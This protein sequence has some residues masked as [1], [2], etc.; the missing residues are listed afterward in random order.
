[1][2]IGLVVLYSAQGFFQP[3]PTLPPNA[4]IIQIDENPWEIG[5]NFPVDCGIQGD[6]KS[7]LAELNELIERGMSPIGQE[8]AKGEPK[9]SRKRSLN[10]TTNSTFRLKMKRI[11]C[12]YPSPPDDGNQRC[13]DSDTVIVDE[14]WSSSGML[15]AGS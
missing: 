5:K 3:E 4:R 15:R 12:R 6:I 1:V 7:T 10:W 9:R 14:C 11:V 8:E 13:D 2:L